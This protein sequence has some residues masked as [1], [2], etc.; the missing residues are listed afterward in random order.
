MK[1]TKFTVLPI[2]NKRLTEECMERAI[3]RS[4]IPDKYKVKI[5]NGKVIISLR[6]SK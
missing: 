2:E 4:H 6:R 1:K 5:I 3:K